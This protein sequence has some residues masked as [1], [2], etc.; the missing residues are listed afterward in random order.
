MILT[1][2]W[3]KSIT[4]HWMVIF[5]PLIVI[6]IITSRLGVVGMLQKL[7]AR[8][9]NAYAPATSEQEQP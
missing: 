6:V 3:L 5:G 7:D 2:E 1:E 4:E 8:R 9:K